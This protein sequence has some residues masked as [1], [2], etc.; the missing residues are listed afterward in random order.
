VES[1]RAAWL[2][3][4]RGPVLVQT[5]H[6]Y[7][8]PLSAEYHYRLSGPGQ[9]FR[10]DYPAYSG[11]AERFSSRHADRTQVVCAAIDPG[12]PCQIW[13]YWARYGQYSMQLRYQ[14]NPKIDGTTFLR[15]VR[16][17]DDHVGQQL[18]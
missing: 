1:R 15:Y 9:A 18:G 11:P 8:G 6:R 16:Y 2:G 5:L 7:A 4:D 12:R 10:D 14:G 3:S 13:F 17:F